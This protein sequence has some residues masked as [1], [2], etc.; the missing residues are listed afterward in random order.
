MPSSSLLK[1]VVYQEWQQNTTCET[2]YTMAKQK[3]LDKLGNYSQN[4]A[5]KLETVLNKIVRDQTFTDEVA[6]KL[7]NKIYLPYIIYIKCHGVYLSPCKLFS[8]QGS[9]NTFP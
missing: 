9:I 8:C 2:Q 5:K 7:F 1:M 6:S 4:D 3:M